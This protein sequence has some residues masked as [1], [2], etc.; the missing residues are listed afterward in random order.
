MKDKLTKQERSDH[1]RRIRKTDTKPE[2]VVR[3]ATHRLGY[4]FRLHSKDLPGTPDLV[5]P[6]LRKIIFVHGCFWHQH[7]GCK[8]A[9]MPKSRL[10][11]W[12][13]KLLRNRQRDEVALAALRKAGWSVRV[14][15]EC[16]V[17]DEQ[18]VASR[19]DCFLSG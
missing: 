8:L 7:E 11:Y 4:R 16:E 13:P 3:R 9:R 19:V 12:Q 1:M 17:A 2:L 6:R 15:W 10:D 18:S 5:F 14:I